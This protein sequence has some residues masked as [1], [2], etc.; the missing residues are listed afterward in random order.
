MAPSTYLGRS[1]SDWPLGC[2]LCSNLRLD[3]ASDRLLGVAVGVIWPDGGGV[4]V[5]GPLLAE[6]LGELR[7]Q[8]LLDAIP[9][10]AD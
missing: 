3:A 8:V 9:L 5:D 6:N 10:V 4:N 2:K 7:G 1:V